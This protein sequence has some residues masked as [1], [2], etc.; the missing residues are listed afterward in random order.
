MIGCGISDHGSVA[1]H[2]EFYSECKKQNMRCSLGVE[3]YI[4]YEQPALKLN[5][6]LTHMVCF[7]RTK[8]GLKDLWKM[9]SYSNDP[10][11][12]Y[13]KPRI[14]LENWI[15]PE[16]NKQYY[17]IEHFN[18][19]RGIVFISG[20]M[21]SA[22]SDCLISD[23]FG[24]PV[25]RKADIKRAYSNYKGVDTEYYRQFLRPNWLE[26]TCKLALKIE[27]LVGKN[28]FYLELQDECN[29]KDEGP[30]WIQPLLCE[31]IRKVGV[32]TGIKCITSGDSHYAT[33]E[34]SPRQRL[35]VAVNIRET[36]AEI[37][38]KL[39]TSDSIDTMP[40]FVSNNFYIH[41]Y[42]E[43]KDKF[44][45]E[46]LDLTNEIAL[47]IEDYDILKKPQIPKFH[48]SKK[49]EYDRFVD[50]IVGDSDKLLAQLSINGAKEIKPWE[51]NKKHKKEDY[52]SRLK[53]ELGI[54]EK[55]NLADYLLSV[56]DFLSFCRNKPSDG[57]YDWMKNL[58][59]K[60]SI[61]PIEIGRG[62]GS[63]GGSLVAY[64]LKI[65]EGDPLKYGLMFNRFFNESRLNDLMDVDSDIES[66]GREEVI[67]YLEFK[68]G[69]K[70]VAQLATYGC[71]KGKATI[72]DVIRV[73]G[74]ENGLEIANKI[75]EHIPDE[76]KIIDQIQEARDAG[77][78]SGIILWSIENSEELQEMYNDPKYRDIFLDSIA[79][80]G[81]KRNVS[82]HASGWVLSDSPLEDNYC[83]IW[84][85]KSKKKIFAWGMKDAQKLGLVKIDI[86]SLSLLDK[87]KYVKKLISCKK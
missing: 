41:S 27:S 42:D 5:R 48:T 4:S 31:C 20:H 81:T 49:Y 54:I 72:K 70:N 46:E 78:E 2:V 28:C 58:D 24:D 65:H 50:N 29:P 7:A 53:Y 85:S 82:K 36:E 34:E 79:I 76:S 38:R 3:L 56:W 62:R 13:Y 55:A 86:L 57:S 19:N 25:K 68:Y 83:L 10:D 52:W 75:C 6:D 35:Q 87:I 12:F 47:S 26:E 43:V 21:G 69:D 37:Q 71:S 45:K 11:L 77:E 9:V 22:I 60:K 51:K 30:L 84:D 64:F 33:I 1:S 18:E 32:S 74:I 66:A 16:T 67:K 80:E 39:S 44:S 15:H 59:N 61:D 17:G 63:V 40:F 23:P 73:K 14:H 8:Q